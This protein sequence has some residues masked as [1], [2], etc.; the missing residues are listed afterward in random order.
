MPTNKLPTLQD[1]IARSGV[2]PSFFGSTG[3]SAF[4]QQLG[5][6]GKQLEGFNKFANIM[7][8]DPNQIEDML[9][10]IGK[11]GEQQTGFIQEQFGA[12]QEAAQS[13]YGRGVE[14]LRSGAFGQMAGARQKTGGF[15]GS[16]AQQSSM[17]LLGQLGRRGMGD[18]QT[19]LS[20][21]IQG[22]T[23][24]RQRGLA[25]LQEQMDARVGQT[26]G[27]LGDY[28]SRL[29]QLGS[30]F[31]SY[32]PEGGDDDDTAFTGW[33]PPDNP[34][35]GQTYTHGGQ[36]YVWD[37]K[38]GDWM[39]QGDEG[40]KDYY[41]DEDDKWVTKDP[42]AEDRDKEKDPVDRIGRKG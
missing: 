15:A 25:G 5:L 26:Q 9:A 23:G 21:K 18:L 2:D 16:G 42:Y 22:L 12:G 29:T 31:L 35:N 30:Q 38:L 28:I 33:S 14:S 19:G 34:Y 37:S 3:T 39:L 27:L 8:F 32:D 10:S 20:E 41:D 1:L 36:S 24:A 13:G 11:F 7:K 6:K 4:G 40:D 17:G